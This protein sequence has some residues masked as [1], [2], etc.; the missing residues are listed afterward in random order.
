M[1]AY[2][3]NSPINYADPSGTIAVEIIVAL[4]KQAA[5]GAVIN[6][7]TSYLAATITGQS[8]TLRD[9]CWAAVAGAG[10]GIHPALGGTIGGIYAAYSSYENGV[11][12][13]G[14]IIS[15]VVSF[16]CTAFSVGGL[17]EFVEGA[18]GVFVDAT[19][20]FASNLISAATY[21]GISKNATKTTK[22]SNINAIPWS[23]PNYSPKS[24]LSA[25]AFWGSS[26]DPVHRNTVACPWMYP[27][28]A[29]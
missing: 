24:S 4:A 27:D 22:S 14:I 2:C 19:F 16:C 29:T 23:S 15:G 1:F 9:G 6:L 7:A 21:T 3:N 8:F 26:N 28:F 10:S 25:N 12:T 13:A 17:S 11:D 5:V 18:A 20:T